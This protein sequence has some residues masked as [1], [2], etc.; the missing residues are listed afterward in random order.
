MNV[1]YLREKNNMEKDYL[2]NSSYIPTIIEV[3]NEIICG[4]EKTIIAGPCT[5]ASYEE[6]YSIAKELK[7]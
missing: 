5:F 7:K 1:I 4:K 3:N 6:A 2:Y